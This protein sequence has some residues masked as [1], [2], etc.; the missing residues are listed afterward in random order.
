[1]RTGSAKGTFEQKLTDGT[2]E[3]IRTARRGKATGGDTDGT[4]PEVRLPVFFRMAHG[5]QDIPRQG[6]GRAI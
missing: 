1:M 2:D 4:G 6:P 3:T 5:L